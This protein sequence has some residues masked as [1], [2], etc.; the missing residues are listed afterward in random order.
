MDL[1]RA[2]RETVAAG[3]Q[4]TEDV[5][6]AA[7]WAAVAEA[8]QPRVPQVG[9]VWRHRYEW[10]FAF[11][12]DFVDVVARGQWVKG[13]TGPQV[14]DFA[15]LHE[16]F[17]FD[18]EATAKAKAEM[19]AANCQAAVDVV[20][21]GTTLAGPPRAELP[22]NP[23]E[24]LAAALTSIADGLAVNAAID[25]LADFARAI[26]EYA[27]NWAPD[28][29]Q[30]TT[31]LRGESARSACPRCGGPAYTGLQHVEC[32]RPGGC[33]T[34]EE[35][36]GEPVVAL[37]MDENNEDLWIAMS[38]EMDVGAPYGRPY[39]H[40]TQAGAIALWREAAIAAERG[41]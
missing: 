28:P 10:A 19:A 31:T 35:R 23:S 34:A 37:G 12:V 38:R 36:I 41:K 25:R 15:A 13:A 27:Y 18:A 2:Y 33:R 9:D 22:D 29:S 11:R 8:T 4:V 20:L 21:A 6:G 16:S 24:A 3:G 40:P 14:I 26:G 32:L 17:T 5:T 1:N 30:P 7:A 39:S